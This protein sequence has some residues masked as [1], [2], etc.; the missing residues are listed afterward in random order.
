MAMRLGPLLLV[1][2]AAVALSACA[3]VRVT[4]AVVGTA[5]GVA[6]F[7]AG[8]AGHAVGAAG[9]AVGVAGPAAGAVLTTAAVTGDVIGL[10]SGGGGQSPK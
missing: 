1:A 4:G 10:A 9:T 6:G 7:A 2:V 5:A 8:A 3:A